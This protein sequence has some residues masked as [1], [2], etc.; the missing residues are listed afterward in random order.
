MKRLMMTL[1]LA[2]L[3]LSYAAAQAP[4]TNTVDNAANNL[5]TMPSFQGGGVENFCYW[6]MSNVEYP[7]RAVKR[8]IE[9][10]V[11]IQFV[12]YPD[13]KMRDYVIVKSPDKSLSKAAKAVLDKANK[14]E[15]GWTAGTDNGKP[16]KVSF[17]L[18]LNFALR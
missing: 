1:M 11:L 12:I 7:K 9:G 2:L 6:A 16:V 13:G 15:N 14:L 3:S 10:M 17:T 8:Q 5:E 4:D 18:P